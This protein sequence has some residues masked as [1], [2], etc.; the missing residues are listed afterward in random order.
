MSPTSPITSI[1]GGVTKVF[2]RHESKASLRSKL[3]ISQG[4]VIATCHF[5]YGVNIAKNIATGSRSYILAVFSA[6]KAKLWQ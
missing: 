1:S 5:Q 2:L 3:W 6:L 4:K